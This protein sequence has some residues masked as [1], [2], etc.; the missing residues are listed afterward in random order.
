MHHKRDMILE[1]EEQDISLQS[2]VPQTHDTNDN[3]SSGFEIVFFNVF[4]F[5][6]LWINT[7]HLPPLPGI[8]VTH[9]DSREEFLLGL[10]LCPGHSAVFS[11]PLGGLRWQPRYGHA[12][13]HADEHF[14]LVEMWQACQCIVCLSFSSQIYV[15][16]D[17]CPQFH[18]LWF[19]DS[20]LMSCRRSYL[21]T[22]FL[23]PSQWN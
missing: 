4:F 11:R 19:S 20:D 3:C 22:N 18:F 13:C 23:E 8:T 7:L 15:M 5:R 14:L 12:R 1:H 16:V 21:V 2:G 6:I 9:H 17:L 10:Q